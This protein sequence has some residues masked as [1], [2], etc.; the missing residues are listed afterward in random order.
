MLPWLA[1]SDCLSGQSAAIALTKHAS[2]MTL[3]PLGAAPHVPAQTR[4]R[5]VAAVINRGGALLL[6]QRPAH[7][8]HGGLWE[9]PGG[10]IHKNETIAAAV[11][12]ELTEELDVVTTHVGE[13]MFSAVDEQSQCE[14]L[15]LPTSIGGEPIAIEHAALRWC[16]PEELLSFDLAPS[17]RAFATFILGNET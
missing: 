8:Q 2:R 4:I 12:R 15:F 17:D 5:V 16:P 13:V 6:C 7:K 10:K 1:S 3:P 14:I 11:A 9:F